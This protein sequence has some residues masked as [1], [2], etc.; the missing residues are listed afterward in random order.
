MTSRR[1]VKVKKPVADGA[2]L[3]RVSCSLQWSGN[4]KLEGTSNIFAFEDKISAP[5]AK[6]D[7]WISKVERENFSAFDTLNPIIDGQ[8]AEIKGQIQKKDEGIRKL[9]RNSFTVNIF[10]VPDEIQDELI[11]MQHDKQPYNNLYRRQTVG[12]PWQDKNLVKWSLS[13]KR[14]RT[15]GPNVTQTEKWKINNA[16]E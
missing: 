2:S 1:R 8:C 15:T 11:E 10:E 9:I 5:I 6:I 13:I 14:L 12:G 16:S 3:Q 7:L 4:M